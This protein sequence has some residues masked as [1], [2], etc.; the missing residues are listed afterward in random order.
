MV[1][2]VLVAA[3]LENKPCKISWKSVDHD[4]KWWMENTKLNRGLV[5]SV[6]SVCSLTEAV[7][8]KIGWKLVDGIDWEIR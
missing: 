5:S 7:N 2:L 3:W 1:D 4:M 6:K 8:S